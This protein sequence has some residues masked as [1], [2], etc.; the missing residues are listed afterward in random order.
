MLTH[1]K[2]NGLVEVR[3]GQVADWVPSRIEDVIDGDL[4]LA[5]PCL[6]GGRSVVALPGDAVSLRWRADKGLGFLEGRL[7]SVFGGRLPIWRV[8]PLGEPIVEQRR[9]FVRVNVTL[10]VVAVVDGAHWLLSTIDLAE[11]GMRCLVETGPAWAVGAEVELHFDVEGVRF[12]ADAKVVW[13][14]QAGYGATVAFAFTGLPRRR[15]D[16]LRRFVFRH[17]ARH[18]H[19]GRR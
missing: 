12:T 4:V 17:E 16:Q 5:A 1:P 10:P 9:Q 6:P 7:V 15:A 8:A 19:V 18:A 3:A 2:V 14:S 13:A 11:G